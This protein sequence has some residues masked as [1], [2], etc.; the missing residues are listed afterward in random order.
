M[1]NKSNKHEGSKGNHPTYKKQ[2]LSLRAKEYKIRAF[3]KLHTV[4]NLLYNRR[5][6]G[7]TVKEFEELL[8]SELVNW[9]WYTNHMSYKMLEVAITKVTNDVSNKVT[10]TSEEVKQSIKEQ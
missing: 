7:M 8:V 4:H 10:A 2:S 1:H 3:F 9:E 5:P 6:T